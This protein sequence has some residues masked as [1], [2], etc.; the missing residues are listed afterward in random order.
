M[1]IVP[2]SSRPGPKTHSGKKPPGGWRTHPLPDH[3]PYFEIERKDQELID[4]FCS[5]P[6]AVAARKLGYTSVD[7]FNHA[8][9]RVA[10]CLDKVA[11]LKGWDDWDTELMPT[12]KLWRSFTEAWR[13]STDSDPR[14]RTRKT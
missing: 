1:D 13:G 11:K 7:S 2:N 6:P 3:N 9:V 10:G 14:E 12:V 4:V 8:V 5:R